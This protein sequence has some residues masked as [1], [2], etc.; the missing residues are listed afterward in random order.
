[1]KKVL[2]GVG[3][4]VLCGLGI[5]LCTYVF[6]SHFI[7]PV[8]PVL[9]AI[10]VILAT[11][12]QRTIIKTETSPIY[13]LT[14]GLV[15]LEGTVSAAA[16]L[17]TPFFKEQ[18]I[19]YSYEK[20]EIDYSD[21]D[22]TEYT[23]SA[24]EKNDFQ[25][26]YLTNST[27]KIKVIASQV[28][29]SFLQPQIKKIHKIKHTERTL[30]NGDAITILGKAVRNKYH[31]FELQE[32]GK[33]PLVISNSA[34]ENRIQKSLRAV[35]YLMPYLIL[36]YLTVNY[37]LFFAPVKI[38]LQ[39]NTAFI[40]FSF[41]GMP[42]L[43]VIFA[44]IG[45]KLNGFAQLL[46]SNLAGICLGVSILTFPLL[47]LLFITETEFYRIICI[48]ASVF[49]FT[50]LAFIMNYRRLDGIFTKDIKSNI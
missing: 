44:L 18:C 3:S 50:T 20:A 21:E 14:E 27:G 8:F 5:I 16:T 17:E 38:Q 35:K 46:L 1:M 37:F 36:M 43:A 15:K 24:V 13:Q 10:L 4:L 2:F 12:T 30:K 23:V 33:N 45:N 31:Q 41:F 19:G 6:F 49:I 22:G 9:I 32:N 11:K 40:L 26:F 28:N 25:N 7:I 47:C 34:I 29:L 42:L 39:K 48:W